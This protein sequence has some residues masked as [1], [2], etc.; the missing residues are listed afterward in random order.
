MRQTGHNRKRPV[1]SLRFAWRF[2]VRLRVYFKGSG[3]GW[4]VAMALALS[5]CGQVVVVETPT[6]A[7]TLEVTADPSLATVPPRPTVTSALPTATKPNT[8]TPSPT[9][10][11]HVVQPGE[12]LIAI[13]LQYGVTV[14]AIQSANGIVDPAAL[15]V[16]QT[17]I[18]PIGAEGTEEESG[19]LLAT[20][21]PVSFVIEG[22][23]CHEQ[24]VG[25]L[26]CLGEVVNSSQASIENVHVRVRLHN[27]AGEE[28][29]RQE[30]QAALDLIQPGQR[31]PFGILFAPA[32][33]GAERFS[34][35]T[36]RAEASTEPASR[37]APLELAEVEAGPVGAL[38]EVTGSVVNPGER[39]VTAIM[40]V[41]TIYDAD[42]QVTGYRQS[43]LA[44][45]LPPGERLPFAVSL[46][47]YGGVP[48]SYGIGVQGRLANP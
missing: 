46:M 31:A 28:L 4:V 7:P 32:P 17:L 10:V 41:V 25:S 14:A 36:V 35:E 3:I 2:F 30:V 9:P 37:Y 8:P 23:D 20:P 22:F 24:L 11:T 5:A 27:A 15:Q 29:A 26:W 34:V 6:L 16:N 33:E 43:R 19:L 39:A 48:D 21:T 47:P 44:E 42:G 45:G 12:T 38:F 40:V 1:P 13:A 18:V